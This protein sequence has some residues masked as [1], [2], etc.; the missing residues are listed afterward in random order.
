MSPAVSWIIWVTVLSCGILCWIF[1]IF[2]FLA[3]RESPRQFSVR[4]ENTALDPQKVL[5]EL[6]SYLIGHLSFK[7]TEAGVLA[8]NFLLCRL[9]MNV[10]KQGEGSVLVSVLD[11]TGLKR[12]MGSIMAVIVLIVEPLVVFGVAFLVWFLALSS[13]V[14][15]VRWQTLQV[16]QMIHV[17]WPPF[18]IYFLFTRFRKEAKRKVESLHTLFEMIE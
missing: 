5:K 11:M 16:F 13:S 18:L 7:K 2:L 9:E 17:L 14:P 8:V 15:A 10:E 1:A 6:S 12:V 3:I 4:T